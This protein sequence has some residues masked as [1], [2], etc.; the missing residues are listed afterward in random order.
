MEKLKIKRITE[1]AKI[2]V[3]GHSTDAGLDVFADEE[4][5]LTPGERAFIKTGIKMAIPEGYVG[6]VWDKGGLA[7]AGIKTIAG[8]VDTDY[9]GEVLIGLYNFGQETYAIKTGEK[10]AQILIQKVEFPEIIEDELD[11]TNRGDGKF[12]STGLI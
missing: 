11:E 12:G 1:T 8:V 6:L 2:P 4:K 9:R 5:D 10:I 7:K 3:R